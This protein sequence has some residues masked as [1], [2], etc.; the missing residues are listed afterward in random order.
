M[1]KRRKENKSL[2]PL[3]LIIALLFVFRFF[4]NT[5][6][7]NMNKKIETRKEFFEELAPY[8]KKEAKKH[9]LFASVILAQAALESNYLNSTLSKEYHNLFGIKANS[10]EKKIT[11]ETFEY[12]GEKKVEE[13]GSFKVYGNIKES[14]KDY[15]NLIGKAKR[16]EPVKNASSREEAAKLLYKCGYSTDPNYGA[17]LISIINNN[18]L[19]IYDN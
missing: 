15:G 3:L 18:N 14:F 12:R 10:K 1:K 4:V 8:A 19:E 11:L 16:Y 2:I 13:L 17:K 6:I 9:N 7:E 5:G